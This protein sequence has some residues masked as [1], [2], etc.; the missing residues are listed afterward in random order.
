M[1]GPLKDWTDAA[2]GFADGAPAIAG[3]EVG[4][5]RWW[6]EVLAGADPPPAYR[7]EDL[8]AWRWGRALTTP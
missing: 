1:L 5:R 8:A 2:R 7:A 6:G 4:L 3:A